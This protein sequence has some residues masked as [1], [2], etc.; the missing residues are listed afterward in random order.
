MGNVEV[1]T[2]MSL[3]AY[4]NF[5][6]KGWIVYSTKNS[7]IHIRVKTKKE[8]EEKA[9]MLRN[10]TVGFEIKIEKW[11]CSISVEQWRMWKKLQKETN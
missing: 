9:K 6:M 7:V 2:K 11:D 1:T 5:G 3:P 10:L 8:A 4:L